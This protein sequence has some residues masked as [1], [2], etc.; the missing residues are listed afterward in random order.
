MGIHKKVVEER[1]FFGVIFD[2]NRSFM[3]H[4]KIDILRVLSSSEWGAA[5]YVLLTMYR[6]LV[7]SW[8]DYGT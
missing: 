4:I 1:T 8:L 3:P 6:T 7:Q 5:R 2:T